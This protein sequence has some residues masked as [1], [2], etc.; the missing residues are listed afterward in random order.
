MSD[1]RKRRRFNSHGSVYKCDGRRKPWKAVITVGFDD[2]GRQQRKVIGY[3][4]TEKEANRACLDCID[5]PNMFIDVPSVEQIYNK[6]ISSKNAS[7]STLRMYKNAWRYFESIKGVKINAV[8][9]LHLQAIID[10]LKKENL[11]YSS[12]HKVKV[13]ATQLFKIAMQN[14]YCEKDYAMFIE[15]PKKPEP[16]NSIF[17]NIDIKKISEYAKAND[18]AK[19]MLIMIYTMLRPSEALM[20]KKENVNIEENFLRAGMKTEAGKNRY[21]PIHRNIK[22]FIVYFYGLNDDENLITYNGKALTYRHFLDLHYEVIDALGIERLSPHKLRKT[23]ATLYK[24]AGVNPNDLQKIIGHSDYSTT[25][26]FYIGSDTG[27]L[28]NAVD[29][30]E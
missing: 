3:F 21:I 30:L 4:L 29:L 10:N 23:G 20:I 27:A 15:L 24:S 11:S 13:L 25:A 28:Q 17:E 7:E 19:A 8:K 2:E 1:K 16:D 18:I 14:D 5:N 22:D 6:F 26:K 9:T 12:L